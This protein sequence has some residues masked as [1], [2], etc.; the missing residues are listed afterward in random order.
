MEAAFVFFA[1]VDPFGWT[2]KN[3][4]CKESIHKKLSSKM[5]DEKW[6]PRQTLVQIR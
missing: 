3:D 2:D 4:K 5:K 6:W 1:A